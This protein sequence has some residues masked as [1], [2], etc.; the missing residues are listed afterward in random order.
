M[1]V[2]VGE[3]QL[4]LRAGREG[5]DSGVTTKGSFW[6]LPRGPWGGRGGRRPGKEGGFLEGGR[7]KVRVRLGG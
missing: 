7:C 6:V 1:R 5:D 2:G 3:I 4:V